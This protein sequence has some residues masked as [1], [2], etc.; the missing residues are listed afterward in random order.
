VA[1]PPFSI[2]K[3]YGTLTDIRDGKTYAT[4]VIQGRTWMAQNLNY[5]TRVNGTLATDDQANDA[6]KEKYCYSD[7]ESN[8]DRYGALYQ[9][10]EAM[11][12][13]A[14][15]NTTSC[16]ASIATGFHQGIC[17]A[18]WHVP[19]AADWGQMTANLAP[20]AEGRPLK[21]GIDWYGS[22]SGN[23]STGFTG[24]GGGYRKYSAGGGGFFLITKNGDFWSADASTGL[25]GNFTY[26]ADFS[27]A[28]ISDG[29]GKTAGQS[30]RCQQDY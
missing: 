23:N 12:L 20:G 17:P 26:L 21:S 22:G 10:A 6:V 2:S 5:G 7:L 19:K 16:A 30:L 13:P 11:A 27:D 25:I 1:W 15:C 24:L 14:S 9:W 28:F 8:C 29:S 18:G 3:T 4:I